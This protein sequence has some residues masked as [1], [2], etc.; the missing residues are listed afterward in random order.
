MTSPGVLAELWRGG[1]SRGL[2]LDAGRVDDGVVAAV[3]AG[4]LGSPDP[5][6][7]QVD[8]VGGGTSSTSKAVLLG[9][10]AA[11][12]VDVEFTFLQVAVD[13]CPC[14]ASRHLREPHGSGRPLRLDHDWVAVE[15][16]SATFGS[17][18]PIPAPPSMP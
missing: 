15:E 6:R 9:T 12:D 13:P 14:R 3:V 10:S 11:S 8:G 17:A 5:L 2:V 1:T 7:R 4:A 16:E 18:A